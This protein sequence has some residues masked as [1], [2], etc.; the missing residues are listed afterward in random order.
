M[1]KF[2]KLY[3]RRLRRANVFEKY[4]LP[5]RDSGDSF[6]AHLENLKREYGFKEPDRGDLEDPDILW[7]SGKPDYSKVRRWCTME[8]LFDKL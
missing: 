2:I 3:H 4:L 6:R 5:V 8:K 1:W 7:R